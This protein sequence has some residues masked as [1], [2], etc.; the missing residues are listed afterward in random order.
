M[1]LP[2]NSQVLVAAP[3]GYETVLQVENL[4]N[5]YNAAS[6]IYYQGGGHG[7]NLAYYLSNLGVRCALYTH[8]G[9]DL[10]GIRA[11]ETMLEAGIDI[12]LCP[13]LA[14]ETS[15]SNFLINIGSSKKTVMN[16]GTALVREVSE[17][18]AMTMPKLFYTSLLPVKPALNLMKKANETGAKVVVGF[19]IPTTVTKSLGL[20]HTT[21]E[22]ALA[23]AGHIMGSYPVL[24]E[25][26]QTNL[27][28]VD[29]VKWL[30]DKFP[31]LETVVITDGK[32]GSYAY[33]EGE[34]LYQPAARIKEVDATGAGDQFI[35]VL[36]KDYIL[37]NMPLAAALR[38]AAFYSAIV[39]SK[40]GSR[41]LVTE[42]E[43]ANLVRRPPID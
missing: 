3:S 41:V 25:E 34:L 8:W 28:T 24:A 35:A 32:N 4:Q 9:D 19:Q 42:E 15:Q 38:R 26:F 13:T 1:E 20:T 18:K 36:L 33:A 22:Q 43:I 5:D 21:V 11:R 16:F 23:Y 17:I 6:N 7:G 40:P 31:Q 27:K 2:G 12:S 10:P 29:L 30:K 39:C 14:G 37:N